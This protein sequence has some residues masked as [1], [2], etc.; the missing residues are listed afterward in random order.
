[1]ARLRGTLVLL[2]AVHHAPKIA[3]VLLEHGR[4]ADTPVLVV[5]NAGTDRQ[6]RLTG[7]L[8]ALAALVETE[9]VRPPATIVIGA[10]VG[11]DPSGRS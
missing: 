2:M 3:G 5:E 1:L 10:V 11:L 8:D 7:R 6:R 4:P 9:A